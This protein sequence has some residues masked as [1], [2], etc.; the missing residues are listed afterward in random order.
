M[1]N[2]MHWPTQIEWIENVEPFVSKDVLFPF[3]LDEVLCRRFQK[4]GL[5]AL[6]S[7]AH[8]NALVLGLRDRR[9]P[10]ADRAIESLR[11]QG[12]DIIVRNSGGTAV[13]LDLGVVNLS[14]ILPTPENPL[15]FHEDFQY[16]AAIVNSASSRWTGAVQA[17][18]VDGA[19]CP[20]D[21]DLSVRGR[22]ICGIS[23][24]RQRYGFAVQAFVNVEGSGEQRANNAATFYTSASGGQEGL[25]FPRV[26]AWKTASIAELAREEADAIQVSTNTF[27]NEVKYFLQNQGIQL[28]ARDVTTLDL[29]EVWNTVE[30]LRT[31]YDR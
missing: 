1:S 11:A 3:A 26:E 21:F 25:M 6:H 17:G 4:G 10:L 16:M 2:R 7:W 18:E 22:K 15:N 27:I 5:P 28:I 20:G 29:E 14:L 30:Q 24:R 13:P 23:Q 31:R 8:A 9:L 19:Y 12:V